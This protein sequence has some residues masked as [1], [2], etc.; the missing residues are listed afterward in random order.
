MNFKAF[1]DWIPIFSGGLQT[2]SSG[3]VHDGD[4]MIDAALASFDPAAHEPPVV[5]GHPAENAPAW[6]W[7]Q[8]LRR[9]VRDSGAGFQPVAILEAKFH[10]VAP[11]FAALV[12]QGRFKK[13]SASFY[14]DGRLR[15]VGFLGAAPPAVKGLAD[16]AFRADDGAAIFEY[17]ESGTGILP[18]NSGLTGQRPVPLHNQ[19]GG[20]SM[21]K[22]FSEFLDGVKALMGFSKEIAASNNPLSVLH[23]ADSASVG[24]HPAFRGTSPRREPVE[25]LQVERPLG[26]T[27]LPLGEGQGEGFFT[28]ADVKKLLDKA[29]ADAKTKA[30]AAFAEE[31]TKILKAQR[32]AELAAQIEA[33]VKSGKIPPALVDMGLKEFLTG[34]D[35]AP[36]VAF[37]ENGQSVQR[38]PA[39]VLLSFLDK[40]EGLGLFKEI[41]TKT[42]AGA[43]F[44]E[45]Q[46]DEK[47]GEL[48]ASKVNPAGRG[49]DQDKRR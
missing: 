16:I 49:N 38:P 35:A 3:R 47:L 22:T 1:D 31:K 12:E 2:D 29:A 44:A 9:S 26:R 14:P 4:A 11:E 27:T 6:G 21:F 42:T 20:F 8:G 10:Q 48:I 23:G 24:A 43:A 39:D 25:S 13:R 37:S 19:T 33:R 41:A 17:Q 32:A 36:P 45:A 30:E 15:H 46:A 28:E 7:V 34:L 40:L 18:V 5:I